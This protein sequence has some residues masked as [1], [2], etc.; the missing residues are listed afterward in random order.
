MICVT[1]AGVDRGSSR[2]SRSAVIRPIMMRKALGASLIAAPF[3]GGVALMVLQ[4]GVLRAA[5]G[6]A[7]VA[8]IYAT[9]WA[10]F[11]LMDNQ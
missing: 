8:L 9:F 7:V 2:Y 1:D 3:S 10:G 4:M 6:M 11:W 5:A